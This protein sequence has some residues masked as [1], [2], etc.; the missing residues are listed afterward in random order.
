MLNS[1][2]Q[3][4]DIG[5][6]NKFKYEK[7]QGKKTEINLS[8]VQEN[9]TL[10]FFLTNTIDGE[11]KERQVS[12]AHYRAKW[13]KTNQSQ[14]AFNTKL[15]IAMTNLVSLCLFEK[16]EYQGVTMMIVMKQLM[17]NRSIPNNILE[18]ILLLLLLLL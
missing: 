1:Q 3:S 6:K 11:A 15:E 10:N 17:F 12:Q 8:D 13:S 7:E 4:C 5:S 2:N 16:H 9:T 18:R 14:K